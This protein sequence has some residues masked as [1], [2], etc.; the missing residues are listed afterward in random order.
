MIVD[1]RPTNCCC[2]GPT[3]RHK[4]PWSLLLCSYDF[5]FFLPAPYKLLHNL[6]LTWSILCF[7]K[8]RIQTKKVFTVELEGQGRWANYKKYDLTGW[9]KGIQVFKLD[10]FLSQKPRTCK[11]EWRKYHCVVFNKC[12]NTM[13]LWKISVN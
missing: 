1:R 2:L 3:H 4:P 5:L 8:P 9:F 12:W 7:L 11:Y 10:E 13:T 6:E